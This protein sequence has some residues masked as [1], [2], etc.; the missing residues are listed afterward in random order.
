[1]IIHT[2]KNGETLR[3]VASLYGVSPIKLAAC[4]GI[5]DEELIPGEE[6]L[7][8]IPTRTANVRRGERLSELCRRFGVRESAVIAMN[9]ELSGNTSVYDGQ[10]ITVKQEPQLW[11]LGIGNG[12][13]YRGATRS[14]L[15][16]TMP[17]LSYVTVCSAISRRGCITS[18]FDDREAISLVKSCGKVPLLRLWASDTGD[19]DKGSFSS[20][21]V[22]AAAKGYRGVTLAGAAAHIDIEL[23]NEAKKA[24]GECELSLI[25]EADV[26]APLFGSGSCDFSVLTYDKIHL[27]PLPSFEKAEKKVFGKYAD[28][29]NATRA[30]AELSPFALIG[31]KYVTK[32]EARAAVRRCGG[33]FEKSEDGC[34]LRGIGSGRGRHR[35]WLLES[36]TNTEKKLRLI[37]ELGFYGVSFDIAR[38]PISELMMFRAMFSDGIRI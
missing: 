8:L 31:E 12:Y 26:D 25:L 2:V 32:A 15:I 19:V 10:P 29:H 22:M 27:D 14:Q 18:I 36:L 7:V 33:R 30:F 9:P 11:G 37:S 34:Y 35:E 3:E 20:L 23:I 16:R 38:V 1:M 4:N 21:A 6:L 28:T 17:Y 24:F 5:F 13:F